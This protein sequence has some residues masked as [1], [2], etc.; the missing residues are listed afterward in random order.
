MGVI[1]PQTIFQ[2]VVV[3]FGLCQEMVQGLAGPLPTCV[4]SG[5]PVGCPVRFC[6]AE[7]QCGQTHPGEHFRPLRVSFGFVLVFSRLSTFTPCGTALLV[8][9]VFG[10]EGV[11]VFQGNP[12]LY[13]SYN[14]PWRPCYLT[15]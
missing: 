12:E 6:C 5:D 3:T 7:V 8:E 14:T 11:V 10:Q 9:Y 15:W 1:S 13:L 2:K 4:D